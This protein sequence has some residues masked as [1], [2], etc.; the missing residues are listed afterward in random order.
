MSLEWRAGK[1]AFLI[2]EAP[3]WELVLEPTSNPDV[4]IAGPGTDLSGENVIFRRDD[5]GRVV[6]V[7]VVQGTYLRLDCDGVGPGRFQAGAY[8]VDGG[9]R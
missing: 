4:F 3:S 6:S 8:R 9:A 7:L 1:L 5:D 2:P